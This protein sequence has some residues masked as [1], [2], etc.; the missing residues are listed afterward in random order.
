M[1]KKWKGLICSLL[2]LL[3]CF[4][5]A[6][7]N[8]ADESRVFVRIEG[9]DQTISQGTVAA[10]TCMEAVQRLGSNQKIPVAVS[11]IAGSSSIYSIQGIA[12]NYYG[13]NDGWIMFVIR[14]Q[15]ML[16]VDD[17]ETMQLKNGDEV[18]VYYGDKDTRKLSLLRA[19]PTEGGLL[20][21]AEDKYSKWSSEGGLK[22]EEII[23]G[24]AGVN[25]H[26]TEP[27]GGVRV[28]ATDKEGS[29]RFAISK[30]GIYQYYGEGYRTGQTPII[31]KTNPGFYLYGIQKESSVTRGEFAAVLVNMKNI[32]GNSGE[33]KGFADTANYRYAPE[34]GKAVSAG[35]L[36][37]YTD[38][39]FQPDKPITLLEAIVVLSK[40]CKEPSAVPEEENVPEWAA[41]SVAAAKE[42]GLLTGV[43]EQY[44]E[45]LQGDQLITLFQ[46]LETL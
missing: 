35:Y 24:I 43:A 5:A 14:D 2:C 4:H 31:V 11:R 1:N 44:Q 7:V 26:L 27:G 6:F 22:Y 20:L 45:P 38:G 42:A 13:K 41:K 17:A 46:N 34:I 29:V 36:N 33:Q 21:F 19:E 37:G 28:S 8:A 3:F 10:V 23:E 25:V 39:S 16:A 18:V 12:N 15:K 9:S 40:Y 30:P 32:K